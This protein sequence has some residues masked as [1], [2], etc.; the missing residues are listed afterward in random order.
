VLGEDRRSRADLSF[1]AAASKTGTAPCQRT[2]SVV[3]TDGGVNGR[4][5]G[6][7]LDTDHVTRLVFRARE[8]WCD[9][10]NGRS[11]RRVDCSEHSEVSD[12]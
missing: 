1:L 11:Q 12:V 8:R 3:G 10:C 7:L 5:W 9:V 6:P 4:T 2:D